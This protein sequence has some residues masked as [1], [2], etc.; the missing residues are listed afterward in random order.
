MA[1]NSIAKA[2]VLITANADELH[3]GLNKAGADVQK[4]GKDVGAKVSSKGGPGSAGGIGGMLGMAGPAALAATAAI[5]LFVVGTEKAIDTLNDLS[6]Q[7]AVAKALGLTAE[8]FTGIA[9]VAKSVGEDTREFTESL[10]TM[11]KLGM[12][13]ASGIG[14]VAGP[15]FQKMG[16]D[17]KEFIKLRA[18]EQFFKIFDSLNGM[19]AGLERTRLIMAA[20]GEDGGKWLLPLLGKAPG[21]IK[22]MAASFAVS[23]EEMAKATAASAAMKRVSA[24]WDRIWRG[25]AIAA[26][27]VIEFIS[28][29]IEK[30]MKVWQPIQDLLTAGWEK[31][32][33][34]FQMGGD[35]I[36]AVWDKTG[37]KIISAAQ[38]IFDYLE[39]GWDAV[40][41]VAGWAWEGIESLVKPVMDDISAFVELGINQI[42]KWGKEV[43]GFGD[44]WHSA[45]DVIIS[46]FR[47]IGTVGAYM[48]D[49]LKIGGGAIIYTAGLIVEAF[50]E[51]V[52]AFQEIL[53]LAGE[54]PDELRPDWLDKFAAGVG[55]FRGDIKGTSDDL[56]KQGKDAMD[57]WGKSAQQFNNWL[58]KMVNRKAALVKPILAPP[59]EIKSDPVK[60]GGA[61][62]KG[63]AEAYSAIV[64]NQYGIL[65]HDATGKKQLAAQQAI[66]KNTEKADGKLGALVE[67]VSGIGI[68]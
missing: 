52:K 20:F 60:L 40:K 27:P 6:K 64:K 62:A 38:P 16:I 17:A 28:K 55:R 67:A 26:A 34:G 58:D 63:S 25:V 8:Q 4:W 43:F 29:G 15:A 53:N 12:D 45:R 3:S 59:E 68:I 49:T 22:K 41:E 61:L 18:D 66:Q 56:K 39:K 37:G 13:A 44:T 1:S 23:T 19:G 36:Q 32:I 2:N 47:D 50:G 21:E 7:D 33:K 48:W 57:S 46:A 65:D 42:I 51:V 14:E 9:G 31:V 54:L 5:G 30:W 10:V 11:G 35:F 24:S